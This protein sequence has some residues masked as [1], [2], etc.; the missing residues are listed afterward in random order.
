MLYKGET[1]V[2]YC[3]KLDKEIRM[4][5]AAATANA[6]TAPSPTAATLFLSTSQA[7]SSDVQTS[8][9]GQHSLEEEEEEEEL[10]YEMKEE[11]HKLSTTSKKSKQ[12]KI[13]MPQ[14]KGGMQLWQFLYALLEDPE[15]RYGDLI[16]WTDNRSELEFRL[17]DPEAIAIWWGNIKH[18]ANMTYERLSRSLRYYYDRGILKKMGGERYLYRFCVDP[19]EMYKHIGNSDSRPVLKPMPLQVSKW[20]YSRMIIP[21]GVFFP[22]TLAPPEYST[23]LLQQQQQT[24]LPP[25]PPYPG[26]PAEQFYL[27]NPVGYEYLSHISQETEIPYTN[28]PQQYES[29][30]QPQELAET[31]YSTSTTLAGCF[32]S[33]V[34]SLCSDS[35][36]Q[37]RS[38]SESTMAVSASTHQINFHSQIPPNTYPLQVDLH[39]AE[40]TACNLHFD[41]GATSPDYSGSTCSGGDCEMVL[42]DILPILASMEQCDE[43]TLLSS[44]HSSLSASSSVSSPSSNHVLSP[45]CT[46]SYGMS[47]GNYSPT[48]TNCHWLNTTEHD[49]STWSA[50]N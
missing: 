30:F 47:I 38:L 20:M 22:T 26:F 13:R 42:D 7:S 46:S 3:R 10:D 45:T 9:K 1:C 48:Y 23:A 16:E 25:P 29:P 49:I 15:K 31:V 11:K 41:G 6:T 18:R 21:H 32:N 28:M 27:P 4:K 35:P 14:R 12:Q 37:G 43:L 36:V 44:H 24:S 2:Q 17:L 50:N 19:E 8:P 5:L 40:S 39:N 33:T 34:T